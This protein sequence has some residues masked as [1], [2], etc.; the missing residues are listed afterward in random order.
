LTLNPYSCK[1]GWKLKIAEN[2][3]I[4]NNIQYYPA[5]HL[6]KNITSERLTLS[7]GEI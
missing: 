3:Q 7:E 5:F 4:L 2:L 6:S 1:S